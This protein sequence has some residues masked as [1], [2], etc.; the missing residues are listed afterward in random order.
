MRLT[1]TRDTSLLHCL[2]IWCA[3]PPLEQRDEFFCTTREVEY[4]FFVG[5][6]YIFEE[7]RVMSD[8]TF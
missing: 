2:A 3:R 1:D 5:N 6:E 7:P 4:L 8:F